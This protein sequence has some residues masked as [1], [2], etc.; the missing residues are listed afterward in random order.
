MPPIAFPTLIPEEF[1]K[2]DKLVEPVPTSGGPET[3]G[4]LAN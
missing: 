4:G 2:E 3:W 1:T